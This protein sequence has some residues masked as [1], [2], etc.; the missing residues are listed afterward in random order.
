MFLVYYEECK[1]KLIKLIEYL[2]NIFNNPLNLKQPNP[3]RLVSA[4]EAGQLLLR[5]NGGKLILFNTSSASNGH[6]SFKPNNPDKNSLP[7]EELIYSP[8]DNNFLYSLGLSLVND[9]I[10]IDIFQTSKGYTNLLTLNQI[11]SPSNGHLYFYKNFTVDQSYKN[12]YNQVS[13]VI[14]RFTGFETV[15]KIKL[16]SK[17]KIK[18]YFTPLLSNK[19]GCSVIPTY[20]T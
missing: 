5:T 9:L 13:R 15:M 19:A 6:N 11:C 12:L 10:S 3:N 17:Y 2:Q 4:I 8:T 20:D 1:E 14:T 7:K 18:E 16:T